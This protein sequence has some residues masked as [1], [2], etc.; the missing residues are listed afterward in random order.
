MPK[1]S[2]AYLQAR[3]SQ[4]LAAA[5][6]CF[7]EKGFHATT[8]QD[9]AR[10]AGVSYGVVYHYFES[11]NDL[12]EATWRP[13]REAREARFRKALERP[14][15]PEALAE[16]LDL[17]VSRM[18]DPEWIPEMRLRIQL[19]G[20]ALL[21]RRIGDDLRSVW[22]EVEEVLEEV[23]R[24][25]QKNG[26]VS[27]DIDARALAQIYLAVHD[28]LLL[29]KTIDPDMDIGNVIEAFWSMH[30]GVLWRRPFERDDDDGSSDGR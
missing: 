26:E 3:R 16:Y 4:V 18:E 12:I 20:E 6:A 25:G 30:R 17:S 24:R 23:I 2:D 8:Q 15:I 10:E 1:V 13:W 28:G 9:I 7:A 19:W 11:K 5:Y 27:A 21:N 29:R 22:R 14:T